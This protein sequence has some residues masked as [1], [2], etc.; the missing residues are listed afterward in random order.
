MLQ[1]GLLI[2]SE[3]PRGH[4][5]LRG[6]RLR[7]DDCPAIDIRHP[8]NRELVDQ[9]GGCIL[10]RFNRNGQLVC[11]VD[12]EFHRDHVA[13]RDMTDRARPRNLS[14][15]LLRTP[16]HYGGM[17]A[18]FECPG[19]GQRCAKLYFSGG[20]FCCRKC[21]GLGYRSQLVARG[22][23]P[24][25]IAQGIRRSLGGSSNLALPF[26]TKP[27][28]MSWRTYFRLR[29]KSEKYEARALARLAAR[30]RRTIIP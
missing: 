27:S 14:I 7:C 18:W 26:P 5:P 9:P 30:F 1:N 24:R 23:R 20:L 22:D 19:C 21:H 29:A 3:L 12:L 2:I 8:Q 28:E 15:S 25:L 4:A 10:W 16:C 13:L 6:G 11:S 17:R